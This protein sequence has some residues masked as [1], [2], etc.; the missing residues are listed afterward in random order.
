MNL[1]SLVGEQPIPILLT[2]RALHPRQHLLLASETTRRVAENLADLPPGAQVQ[3]IEPYHIAVAADQVSELWSPGT[4]VNL[5]GGTKP[6]ALAAYEVARRNG[7][8]VVYLQSEGPHNVLYRYRAE[9]DRLSLLQ[10]CLLLALINLD[11]YL[12]A[13]VGDYDISGFSSGKGGDLER[14][15]FEALEPFVDEIVP[16]IRMEA[17]VVDIDLAVRVGNKVGLIECKCGRNKIKQAID[18]LNTAGGQRY[19]GTYAAKFLVSD[20]DWSER[21]NLKAL[22]QARNITVVHVPCFA[23]AGEITPRE[24]SILRELVLRKLGSAP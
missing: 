3:V 7:A 9:D 22:A 4:V 21:Y 16:G 13:H 8:E 23:K 5:T 20:Q 18:Q 14:A 11:D 17:G 19:L 24:V 15:T 10:R 1:L 2:W 6:M 12:R